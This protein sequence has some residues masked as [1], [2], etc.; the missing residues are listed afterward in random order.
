M[1]LS[2][3]ELSETV[4]LYKDR[5]EV[6]LSKSIIDRL[7][8]KKTVCVS[9]PIKLRSVGRRNKIILSEASQNT[10]NQELLLCVEKSWKKYQTLSKGKLRSVQELAK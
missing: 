7:G 5:L 6:T 3:Q 1:Q 9:Y 2:V 4:V 8:L 10:P